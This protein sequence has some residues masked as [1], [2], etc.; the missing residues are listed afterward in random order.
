MKERCRAYFKVAN[1]AKVVYVANNKLFVDEGAARSYCADVVAV[2][3]SEV[4]AT[5]AE[6]V[7][8]PTDGSEEKSNPKTKE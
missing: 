7:K 2:K 6:V 4:M 5:E 1:K 8:L 3:R